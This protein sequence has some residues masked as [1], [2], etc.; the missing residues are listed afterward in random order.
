VIRRALALA[1]L[2]PLAAAADRDPLEG[3]IAGKPVNCIDAQTYQPSIVDS[4]TILYRSTNR[5]IYRTGPVGN[6]PSL[7]PLSTLVVDLYGSQ[8]CRNDRFRVVSPGISIPSAYC[9]F[10]DFTPYDLP[11]KRR[12]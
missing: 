5:R 3:R 12:R 6:C 8:L 10:S 1:A 4:R 7:E 11:P 9:R 2:L